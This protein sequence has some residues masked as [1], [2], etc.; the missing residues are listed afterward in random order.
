MESLQLRRWGSLVA[1]LTK[2][3]LGKLFEAFASEFEKLLDKYPDLNILAIV[4]S[5]ES[6]TE[7]DKLLALSG[8]LCPICAQIDLVR[9]ILLKN[10]KH[11][12]ME[13]PMLNL[14][15]MPTQGRKDH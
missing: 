13:D 8:Q 1:S 12:G 14:L 3:Q 6:D 11:T 4:S 7:G 15:N 10:L 2:D 9:M 5:T